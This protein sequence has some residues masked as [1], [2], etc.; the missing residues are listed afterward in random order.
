MQMKL[1][2]LFVIIAI[3]FAGYYYIAHNP[4]NASRT[5]SSPPHQDIPYAD[6]GE[7]YPPV[8]YLQ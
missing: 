4:C 1:S 7:D 5:P 6:P 2:T 3:I 8:T